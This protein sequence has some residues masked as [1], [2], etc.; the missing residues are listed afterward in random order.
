MTKYRDMF[1]REIDVGTYLLRTHALGRSTAMSVSKVVKLGVRGKFNFPT[2][3]VYSVRPGWREE[4][5]RINPGTIQFLNR[6]VVVQRDFLP[7]EVA[8]LLD[9]EAS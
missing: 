8:D 6:C 3:R 1:G 9:Q 5:E 2:V 7:T 4:W